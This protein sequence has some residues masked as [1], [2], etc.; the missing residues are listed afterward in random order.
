MGHPSPNHQLDV[1]RLGLFLPTP[2]WA[3]GTSINPKALHKT[4]LIHDHARWAKVWVKFQARAQKPG[5][6][7]PK[8]VSTTLHLR[9]SLRII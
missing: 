9:P 4:L 5:L 6:Q 3:R 8:G 1:H 7:G 2:P